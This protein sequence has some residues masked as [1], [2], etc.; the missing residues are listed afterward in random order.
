MENI[1]NYT[2]VDKIKNKKGEDT[3]EF[4]ECDGRLIIKQY[5]GTNTDN[6]VIKKMDGK[7]LNFAFFKINGIYYVN[8]NGEH[9]IDYRRFIS[10][11]QI[12]KLETENEDTD[13]EEKSSSIKVKNRYIGDL[14]IH[15]C[16]PEMFQKSL[17]IMQKH[18]K[19]KNSY[20]NDFMYFMF[21]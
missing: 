10:I 12:S 14:I 9:I 4:K 19:N 20:Y 3:T 7:R 2:L 11:Q 1:E 21:N 13:N 18:M 17:S 15:N 8:I 16:D 5:S 6:F